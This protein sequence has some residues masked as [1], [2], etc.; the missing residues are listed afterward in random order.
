MRDKSLPRPLRLIEASRA[1][2]LPPSENM[3]KRYILLTTPILFLLSFLIT[4]WLFSSIQQITQKKTVI[5]D[6]GETPYFAVPLSDF[7]KDNS[8]IFQ[9]PLLFL[10]FDI[11]ANNNVTATTTDGQATST[12]LNI[13]ILREYNKSGKIKTGQT[14]IVK[15]NIS[16]YNLYGLSFERSFDPTGIATTTLRG[17]YT[18]SLSPTLLTFI[19]TW[20]IIDIPIAYAFIVIFS[21]C[22]KFVLLGFPFIDV[23]NEFRKG[24]KEIFKNLNNKP[25]T[26]PPQTKS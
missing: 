3:K 16:P 23:I 21:S 10:R 19:T 11:Y 14:K 1:G 18:L 9:I 8:P 13:D 25:P 17:D 7:L 15:E 2:G 4:F 26:D 5:D 20:I 12:L 22:L 24:K 6:S